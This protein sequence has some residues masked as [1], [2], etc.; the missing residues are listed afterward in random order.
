[1]NL[2]NN[3]HITNTIYT[4]PLINKIYEIKYLITY[5]TDN[6]MYLER[7]KTIRNEIW[8]NLKQLDQH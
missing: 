3:I 1:M 4:S 7:F 2:I 6:I 8:E 5:K